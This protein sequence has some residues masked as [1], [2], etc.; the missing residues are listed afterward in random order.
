[1]PKQYSAD[2]NW[3]V[4]VTIAPLADGRARFTVTG[5][6]EDL[7]EV[8]SEEFVIAVTEQYPTDGPKRV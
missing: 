3:E 2:E 6:P 4:C 5:T 8:F 1:M 7:A